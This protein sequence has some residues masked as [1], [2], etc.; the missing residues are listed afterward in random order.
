MGHRGSF[1]RREWFDFMTA[2]PEK[3]TPRNE[4]RGAPLAT[5][6]GKECG[7]GPDDATHPSRGAIRVRFVTP[8]VTG[9]YL[10]KV[11][12]PA[13][14]TDG[15]GDTANVRADGSIIHGLDPCNTPAQRRHDGNIHLDLRFPIVSTTY[16]FIYTMIPAGALELVA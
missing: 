16:G 15:A 5:T 10:A 13:V 12:G 1:A 2:R 3:A 4:S 14:A 11:K 8:A 9:R 7:L 6:P